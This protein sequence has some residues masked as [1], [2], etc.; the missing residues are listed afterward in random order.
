MDNAN[1]HRNDFSKEFETY[2]D[3]YSLWTERDCRR[4]ADVRSFAATG[5]HNFPEIDVDGDGFLSRGELQDAVQT[6]PTCD[7]DIYYSLSRHLDEIEVLHNDEWG[8]ENNGISKKDLDAFDALQKQTR[9][10][11]SKY[12]ALNLILAKNFHEIDRNDDAFMTEKELSN[13]AVSTGDKELIAE[14]DHALTSM[15][16]G[17]EEY[18]PKNSLSWSD[19][20]IHELKILSEPHHRLVVE[21]DSELD[22]D[23]RRRASDILCSTQKNFAAMDKDADGYLSESDLQSMIADRSCEAELRRLAKFLNDF[24]LAFSA[25]SP[26]TKDSWRGCARGISRVDLAAASEVLAHAAFDADY[27]AW[28]RSQIGGYFDFY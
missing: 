14:I 11:L 20:H 27:S 3:S 4:Y 9:I 26:F 2:F 17:T 25:M 10:E 15:A 23:A 21:I 13:F 12:R 22:V 7:Q 24:H 6:Q 19:I 8:A 16:R 1:S 5:L 28:R 18:R